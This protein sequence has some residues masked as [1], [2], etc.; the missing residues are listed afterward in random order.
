MRWPDIQATETVQKEYVISQENA[1]KIMEQSSSCQDIAQPSLT[2]PPK[3]LIVAAIK[4][5]ALNVDPPAAV[6]ATFNLTK[7]VTHA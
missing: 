5:T 4:S 3:V 2:G 1:W 6:F 7:G